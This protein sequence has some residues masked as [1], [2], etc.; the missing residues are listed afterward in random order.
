MVMKFTDNGLFNSENKTAIIMR[1]GIYTYYTAEFP[2][3]GGDPLKKLRV[4]RS[5]ESVKAA[6]KRFKELGRIPVVYEHPAEDMDPRDF[7]QGYGYEPELKE[8]EGRMCIVC[9][10]HLQDKSAEAYETGIKEISC[11]WSGEF[12]KAEEPN[13]PFDYEQ[14]FTDFNHIALVPEGRCGALCSI[15]DQKGAVIMTK[16]ED[17]KGLFATLG[18]FA[19][20]ICNIAKESDEIKDA[21]AEG[22][23]AAVQG[24]KTAVAGLEAFAKE[25]EKEEPKLDVSA[26]DEEP[27]E[28]KADEPKAEEAKVEDEEPESKKAEEQKEPEEDE[29]DENGELKIKDASV[30]AY[31]DK[32][33]L[34][35][36]NEGMKIAVSRFHDVLPYIADGTI[37]M[38]EIKDGATPCEI[39]QAFVEKITGKK[40]TDAAVLS[41]AFELATKMN[42]ADKWK[43]KEFHADVLDE[44]AAEID[45]IGVSKKETK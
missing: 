7:K 20:E 27:K 36:K 38:D 5:A 6:Y 23:L 19:D 26:T 31:F 3:L 17:K 39:K 37:P 43:A 41:A 9:K 2:E 12:V 44:K 18:K 24:L 30:R 11:G 40:Y 34:D 32:K 29:V 35:A 16:Q 10:L 4:Y 28:P 45:R 8:E 13:A 42:F 1:D 33:I 14:K 15:K 22:L 21:H 25:E